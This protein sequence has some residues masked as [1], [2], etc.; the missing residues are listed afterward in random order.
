MDHPTA[1]QVA[2]LEAGLNHFNPQVRAHNLTQLA[3]LA[4]KGAIALA[5]EA[6][7]A[8]M[9]CHTLTCWQRS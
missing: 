3:A 4:D 9:H 5:P 1:R 6:D 2:A 7:V 8:N